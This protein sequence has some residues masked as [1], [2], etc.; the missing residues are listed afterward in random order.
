MENNIK[1]WH[2]VEI[3]EIFKSG[4]YVYQKSTS[5]TAYCFKE[6]RKFTFAKDCQC[7]I[8][9]DHDLLLEAFNGMQ[10]K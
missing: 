7:E 10:N 1:L 5:R 8:L 4:K 2:D 9:G 6:R 3:G